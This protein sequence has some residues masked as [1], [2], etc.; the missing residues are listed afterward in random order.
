MCEEGTNLPLCFGFQGSI[1]F[2]DVIMNLLTC[3]VISSWM[4]SGLITLYFYGEHFNS[5]Q[6][7]LEKVIVR[8]GLVYRAYNTTVQSVTVKGK[9]AL[10]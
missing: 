10:L 2:P 6:K 9:H 4:I 8:T 7:Q 1:N 5:L 3:Q